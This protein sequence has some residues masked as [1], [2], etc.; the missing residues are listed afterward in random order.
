MIWRFSFVGE[1]YG[2]SRIS[3]ERK[4]CAQDQK[5]LVLLS[6]TSFQKLRTHSQ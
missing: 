6:I 3:L 4:Y 1:I 5:Q 2:E